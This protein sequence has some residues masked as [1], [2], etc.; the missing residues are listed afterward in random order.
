MKAVTKILA[1]AGF[2]LITSATIA[3]ERYKDAQAMGHNKCSVPSGRY[4]VS[5]NLGDSDRYSATLWVTGCQVNM[6]IE[7]RTK[8]NN[9]GDYLITR[10][11][12]H[13]SDARPM[14]H[15]KKGKGHGHEK[16]RGFHGRQGGAKLCR[17]NTVNFNFGEGHIAI[18]NPSD[19]MGEVR[20]EYKE[21]G[22]YLT[23][24]IKLGEENTIL[25][26]A[27]VDLFKQ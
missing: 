1:V 17:G 6:V 23:G 7:D 5:G 26:D 22:N 8:P 15:N 4:I 13:E 24:S 25:N 14:R 2:S 10:N 16:H 19:L 27:T 12:I 11:R 3:C 18:A 9:A 21:E 20:L